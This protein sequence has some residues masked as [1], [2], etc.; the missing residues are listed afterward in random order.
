MALLI[1]M[2]GTFPDT[3]LSS[4][5]TSAAM[6]LRTKAT[7][8]KIT[9]SQ[10]VTTLFAKQLSVPF[11]LFAARLRGMLPVVIPRTTSA[12]RF[13]VETARTATTW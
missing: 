12:L 1:Q 4:V 2:N 3:R 11:A 5:V 8:A 13:A 7:A 6:T 10:V 9:R